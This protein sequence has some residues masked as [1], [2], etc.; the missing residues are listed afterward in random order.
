MTKR[1]WQKNTVLRNSFEKIQKGMAPCVLPTLAMNTHV[2][3]EVEIWIPEETGSDDIHI[4]FYLEG[5][6]R[7]GKSFGFGE[8]MHLTMKIRDPNAAANN[9]V[10]NEGNEAKMIEDAMNLSDNG[11]GTFEACLHQLKEADGDRAK[12]E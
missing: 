5:M 1:D 8:D 7:R 11:F 3:V 6:D 9:P 2:V 12:A 4:K 10:F